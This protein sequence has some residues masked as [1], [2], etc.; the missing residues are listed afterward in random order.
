V[1]ASWPG[2]ERFFFRGRVV[3][4]VT[5]RNAL[6]TSL[7]IAGPG[8]AFAHLVSARAS[9]RFGTWIT[10]FAYALLAFVLFWLFRCALSDPGILPR[11]KR[12]EN[13]TQGMTERERRA[14][15]R[16]GVALATKKRATA[17]W[18]ETCGY[19][20]PLRAHH[21]SVTNDCIEK[22]DHH[23]PWTGAT[24]GARN[25]RAFL[26]FVMSCAA[27]AAY[28]C[29][30]CAIVI[31]D[32]SKHRDVERAMASSWMPL[33]LLVYA[34]IGLTFVGALMCFH[35]YLVATNQ[36]TYE[37][38]RDGYSWDANPFNRGSVWK[39]CGEVW[40]GKIPRAR[41]KFYAFV[42]EDTSAEE[43][44]RELEE[45]ERLEAEALLELERAEF[46]DA[47]RGSELDDVL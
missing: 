22:F 19:Y 11:I 2:N 29:A 37:S 7:L 41:I 45:N 40:C 9:A 42:D 39:N 36:T 12:V 34:S 32:G 15:T 6:F 8:I 35:C 23:C 46:D 20:Q 26:I 31:E 33:V 30:I 28:V 27:Y 47:E 43:F 38:F 13:T 5:P 44:A 1:Y 14:K 21:C 17:R 4:G 18:N 25:Y 24:I 16:E 3:A 10:A